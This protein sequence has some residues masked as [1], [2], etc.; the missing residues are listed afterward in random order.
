M[1]AAFVPKPGRIEVDEF[2]IPEI[3]DG[4]L[5]VRMSL[6]SICGSDLH[7]LYHGFHNDAGLGVPGYPGHEGVGEVVDSRSPRFGTGQQVLTVPVGNLGQCFAQYQRID[8]GQ[9]L[10][11][12]PGG[13][14][15]LLLGQQL[16]TTI[17]A[18]KKFWRHGPVDGSGRVAAVLGAGSAGLFFVQ[19]VKRLGFDTVIVSDRAADRL[20]VA[21]RLGADLTVHVP[22]ERLTEAVADI[23]GGRGADFVIEAAGFDALRS[24]A[25]QIL[26]DHGTLGL[27]GFPERY[28]GAQFP[29][30]DAFR[31]SAS[32]E[33][34]CGAQA[35]P[36][37]VSFAEALHLINDGTIEVEYCTG[38]DVGLDSIAEAFERAEDLGR[39]AVKIGIEI[40]T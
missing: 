33:L 26:A 37:L 6:A 2:P 9:V 19:H 39:G 25:V 23:T 5:L 24:T 11:L 27:Y 32:V 36:G 15:K 21:R 29:I 20:E 30:Y 17:Y 1:R 40:G 12:P 10:A 16:G 35:E 38:T 31:K 13:P 18:M 8:A 28:G 14:R 22:D 4:E 7:V 34:V 3:S